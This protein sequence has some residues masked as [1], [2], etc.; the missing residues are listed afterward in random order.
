MVC[1]E[2]F[3]GLELEDVVIDK[4]P[5]H[6]WVQPN[7]LGLLRNDQSERQLTLHPELLRLG[8]FDYVEALKAIKEPRLF[9]ELVSPSSK[10]PLGDRSYDEWS[11][12]NEA[13]LR[14]ARA[15]SFLQQ[16]AQAEVRHV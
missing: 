3:F 5:R 8:L 7:S 10:S 15:A 11:P 4:G 2:E 6:I 14:A 1:R 12:P 9:P 16:R 13:R